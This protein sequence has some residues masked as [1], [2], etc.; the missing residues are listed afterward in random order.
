MLNDFVMDHY[1]LTQTPAKIS[2]RIHRIWINQNHILDWD[3]RGAY[4]IMGEG[5]YPATSSPD[6]ISACMWSLTMRTVSVIILSLCCISLVTAIFCFTKKA[7][8]IILL[9]ALTRLALHLTQ[10]F[11][12]F[13]EWLYLFNTLA[14]ANHCLDRSLNAVQPISCY[15]GWV[16]ERE[17]QSEQNESLLDFENRL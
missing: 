17:L 7:T 6:M 8:A 4:D 2:L 15:F 11:S 14:R 13:M 16:D 10:V 5:P 12:P 3:E 1:I 9:A